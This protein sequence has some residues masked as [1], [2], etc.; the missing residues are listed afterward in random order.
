MHLS[1]PKETIVEN[2]QNGEAQLTKQVNYET[3][4]YENIKYKYEILDVIIEIE[5]NVSRVNVSEKKEVIHDYTS[6]SL[7]NFAEVEN[8]KSNN[9]L[10]TY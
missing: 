6:A 5:K 1:T 9:K 2:A 10:S 7:L 4:H 8:G 3:K